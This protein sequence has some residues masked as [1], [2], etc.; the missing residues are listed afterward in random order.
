[1]TLDEMFPSVESFARDAPESHTALRWREFAPRRGVQNLDKRALG[2]NRYA[3]SGD[4]TVTV[5]SLHS[6]PN[7]KTGRLSPA[8]GV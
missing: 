2:L 8:D 6:T 4:T 7:A 1:M 5:V 3:V